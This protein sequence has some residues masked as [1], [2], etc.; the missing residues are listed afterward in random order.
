MAH[1]KGL[2]ILLNCASSLVHEGAQLAVLGSGDPTLEFGFNQLAKAHPGRVSV[3][4]GYNEP[5]SHQ[6]MAGS[7]I[8]L[9]PSRFEPCG[10]NQMY[11]LAYG[12]PPVV[13]HTG[14]LADSV[15]DLDVAAPNLSKANGFVFYKATEVAFL[16]AVRR[17]I[18]TFHDKK[19]WVALQQNGMKQDLSW[20]PSAKKYLGI[21]RDLLKS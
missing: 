6:I 21:Y 19:I 11:G 8:F 14:G 7:D 15:H 13:R 12:T 5:L 16:A 17:A 2:D 20:V 9:M 10:L 18:A 1:Q 3:T 4:I